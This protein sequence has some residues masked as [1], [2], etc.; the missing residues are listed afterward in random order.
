VLAIDL[1]LHGV[2]DKTDPFYVAGHER[3]FDLDLENNDSG[4]AGSD[5]KIDGSG[6][7]FI[8]L[9]STITSRDNLREGAADLLN[10][11]ASL[12]NIKP[13]GTITLDS[14]KVFFVGHSLGGIVGTDF[15]GADTDAAALTS[16]LPKVTVGVLAMPG[17]HIAELLRNSPTFGPIID[18]GL[19]AQG[20]VKGSQAYYDFYSEAQAVVEDGDPANYAADAA[21]G[22]LIHMI[23]VVG[24][25]DASSPPDQV[26]PNSATDVLIG[27]MGITST[28]TSSAPLAVAAPTLAQFTS[29]DHGSILDPTAPTG[30]SGTVQAEYLAVT[31]EMQTEMT[32]AVFNTL[33][34]SPGVTVAS[35]T[36]LSA[37]L[38]K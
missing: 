10:L 30:A 34:G 2:T 38:K 36:F 9:T 27:E 5:G 8:N 21:A 29:G 35:N 33:G 22:H 13:G 12:P 14:S 32:T 31:T 19:A 17:A 16:T 26:V 15:L 25:H 4:A 18:Q 3:T 6:T 24:G 37:T 28:I 11:V 1:P 20:L 7:W 23:E